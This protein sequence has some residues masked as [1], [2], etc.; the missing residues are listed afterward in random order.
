MSSN[1]ENNE[2]VVA[3]LSRN[4]LLKADEQTRLKALAL[5]ITEAYKFRG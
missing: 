1:I 5:A 3:A 4:K 2:Y